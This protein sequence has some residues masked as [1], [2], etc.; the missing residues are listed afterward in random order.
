MLQC[1][2]RPTLCVG[3]FPGCS[4]SSLVTWWLQRIRGKIRL[5]SSQIH[6]S[7][8]FGSRIQRWKTAHRAEP[9]KLRLAPRGPLD[10]SEA[11]QP[12]MSSS[13]L[14]SA[15]GFVYKRAN[16]E[17][18]QRLATSLRPLRQLGMMGSKPSRSA[19]ISSRFKSSAAVPEEPELGEFLDYMEKLK[20]YERVGVPL[21]AGTD[22]D[23]GFDLGR[24]RRLL[25]RLGNPH[26]QFKVCDSLVSKLILADLLQRKK[27]PL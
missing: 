27:T 23:D 11:T 9:S 6:R 20:N 26:K 4:S 2:K 1:V 24:M 3:S 14:S 5:M 17:A 19:S 21:G 13:S 7:Y 8:C 15:P 16:R 25:Q 10:P 18:M 22:T 12:T